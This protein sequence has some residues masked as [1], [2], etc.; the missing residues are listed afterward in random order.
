M[1]LENENRGG[2]DFLRIRLLHNIIFSAPSTPSTDSVSPSG[3]E[4]L[5]VIRCVPSASSDLCLQTPTSIARN[6]IDRTLYYFTILI[7]RYRPFRLLSFIQGSNRTSYLS[8]RVSI[9]ASPN[10]LSRTIE[11][12]LW[13][14]FFLKN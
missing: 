8:P 1:A 13:K 11:E 4:T 9:L 12:N 7:F 2:G 3:Y 5:V 14:S 6:D 10:T